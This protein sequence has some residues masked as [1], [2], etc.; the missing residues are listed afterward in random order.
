MGP[1]AA[2]EEAPVCQ[3]NSL[4][5]GG[6]VYAAGGRHKRACL[7]GKEW[8]YVCGRECQREAVMNDR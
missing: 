7:S 5:G 8:V 3:V 4:C 6:S 1:L 2:C